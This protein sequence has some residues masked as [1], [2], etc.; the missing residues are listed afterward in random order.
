MKT[1]RNQGALRSFLE[2]MFANKA[3]VPLPF[4]CFLG[5]GADIS[6]APSSS[7]HRHDIFS[8]SLRIPTLLPLG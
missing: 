8:A 2:L 5:E 4:L 1:R 7:L 6:D 3:R